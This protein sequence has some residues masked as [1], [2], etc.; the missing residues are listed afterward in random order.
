MK[1]FSIIL[2]LITTGI[3]F[4]F[5]ARPFEDLAT[6]GQRLQPLFRFPAKQLVAPVV[7][8]V[9]GSAGW[10]ALRPVHGDTWRQAK[11]V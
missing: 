5:L 6:L 10:A 8:N 2:I 7:P 9:A 4:R 3:F 1:L 11:Q